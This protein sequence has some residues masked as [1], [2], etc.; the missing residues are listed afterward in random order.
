MTNYTPVTE[1]DLIDSVDENVEFECSVEWIARLSAD[2]YLIDA[3]LESKY[4]KL[5]L[6]GNNIKNSEALLNVNNEVKVRG[7]TMGEWRSD[8][9]FICGVFVDEAVL[10]NGSFA[11]NKKE[12]TR[13]AVDSELFVSIEEKLFWKIFKKKHYLIPNRKLSWAPY[14][15]P[16]FTL[17]DSEGDI[18]AFIEID[19]KQHDEDFCDDVMRDVMIEKREGARVFRKSAEW[20]RNLAERLG[21]EV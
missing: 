4:V 10:I 3:C 2:K 1:D 7:K 6:H 12:V 5:Q 13:P 20:V 18:V 17:L 8:K 11:E 15:T 9:G 16:D 21:V 19:G 14:Y